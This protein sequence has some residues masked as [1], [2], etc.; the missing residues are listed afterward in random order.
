MQNGERLKTILYFNFRGDFSSQFSPFFIIWVTYS[1]DV[2]Q[3]RLWPPS[4]F[5][6]T[7]VDIMY[8]LVDG[9]VIIAF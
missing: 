9:K 6:F 3:N 7:V 1:L 5:G 8:V 4:A 2:I